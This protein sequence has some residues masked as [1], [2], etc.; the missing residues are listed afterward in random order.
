LNIGGGLSRLFC[1]SRTADSRCR[2][3]IA[4]SQRHF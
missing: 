1:S 3:P 2:V 4:E